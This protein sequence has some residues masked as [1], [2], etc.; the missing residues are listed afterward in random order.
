MYRQLVKDTPENSIMDSLAKTAV[1]QVMSK[2]L[3]EEIFP[4][5]CD[6]ILLICDMLLPH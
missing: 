5:F 3:M 6:I 4:C 2:I 1:K